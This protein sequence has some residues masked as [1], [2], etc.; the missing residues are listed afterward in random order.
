MPV[1]CS[2]GKNDSPGKH[3]AI[4]CRYDESAIRLLDRCDLSVFDLHT[5]GRRLA[6]HLLGQGEARNAL[7]SGVVLDLVDEHQL[8]AGG[9]GIKKEHVVSRSGSISCSAHACR[10]CSDHY[11][12]I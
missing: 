2:H 5:E 4:T 9:C 1:A 12:I 6:F 8:T 10:S 11:D 7:E 3:I